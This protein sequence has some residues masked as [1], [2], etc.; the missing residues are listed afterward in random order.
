MVL[1]DNQWSAIYSLAAQNDAGGGEFT[2][3][4]YLSTGEFLGAVEGVIDRANAE[5]GRVLARRTR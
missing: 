4:L 1:T 3:N 5:S 2:G